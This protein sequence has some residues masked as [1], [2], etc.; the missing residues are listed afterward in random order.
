MD[1]ESKENLFPGFQQQKTT[2]LEERA[3]GIWASRE[4]HQILYTQ[5]G[6]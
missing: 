3:P 1:P 2:G 6:Q 4:C 5:A